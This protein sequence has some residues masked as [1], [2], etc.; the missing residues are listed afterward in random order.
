MYA[1][2]MEEYPY[3]GLVDEA[4]TASQA[5][6]DEIYR[7]TGIQCKLNKLNVKGQLYIPVYN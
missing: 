5:D 7:L 1:I 4:I 6:I 2:N 3:D